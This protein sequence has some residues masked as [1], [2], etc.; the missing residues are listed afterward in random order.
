MPLMVWD[1]DDLIHNIEK[2]YSDLSDEIVKDIARR[3]MKGMWGVTE[4]AA[5][6]AQ[7]LNDSG[8]VY[9][10]ILG[11]VNARI[12]W[13]KTELDKAFKAAGVKAVKYDDMIYKAAGLEPLV[14]N[15]SHAAQTV[16]VAGLEKTGGVMENLAMSMP[17]AG[18]KLYLDTVDK[19]YMKVSSGAFS[20]TE[21][22]RSAIKEM[23]AKGITVVKYT[24]KVDQIDVAMRRAMLTGIS[25][26]ANR[27]QI[28]RA[29]EIGADYV[30]VSAHIGARPTHQV[31]QGKIYS[32]RGSETKYGNFVIETHYGEG[33]GLGGWNCRHS[34]F[35][36]F[37]GISADYY[38]PEEL[39]KYEG[40]DV[41]YNG[42][43]MD[44]YSAT[45]QQRAIE[46]EIR[47]WKRQADALGAA[48]LDNQFELGKKAEWQTTM[49]D[50][51]KQ[52]GLVRQPT[53]EG[54]KILRVIKPGFVP[55][56]W[57]PGM[58]PPSPNL[59]NDALWKKVIAK[60]NKG[61]AIP[62]LGPEQALLIKL[63]ALAAP[64]G[65][66]RRMIAALKAHLAD[67]LKYKVLIELD[68]TGKIGAVLGYSETFD[69]YT[70]YSFGEI[71][72]GMGLDNEV[73]HKLFQE[74]LQ[75]N[76]GIFMVLGTAG[77]PP[78][79]EYFAMKSY[80]ESL[81]I[82]VQNMKINIPKQDVAAQWITTF[83]QD[84]LVQYLAANP[85][86]PIPA[87]VV[88][89]SVV[90]LPQ[91]IIG[92][93]L[94]LPGFSK[95]AV[96][97]KPGDQLL[98]DVAEAA[99]MQLKKNDY[100]LYL[101]GLEKAGNLT[102]KVDRKM[103]EMLKNERAGG[104]KTFV[105]LDAQGNINSM[106]VYSLPT[107]DLLHIDGI[108]GNST[109]SMREVMKP[110]F[111]EAMLE[112]RMIQVR[113]ITS[114]ERDFYN[115]IGF[116]PIAGNL[117]GLDASELKPL[118]ISIWG[119]NSYAAFATKY[120]AILPVTPLQAFS[121]LPQHLSSINTGQR[122]I[123]KDGKAIIIG[124]PPKYIRGAYEKAIV[125][126][127]GDGDA[128]IKANYDP[129]GHLGWGDYNYSITEGLAYRENGAYEV[130][131]LLHLGI[132]PKSQ[133]F[134]STDG[135]TYVLIELKQ[136]TAKAWTE[137]E[138]L[139]GQNK[140]TYKDFLAAN[141]RNKEEGAKLT[142][143][144]LITGQRDRNGG[145]WMVDVMSNKTYA[146]DNG[147]SFIDVKNAATT[148]AEP[149]NGFQNYRAMLMKNGRVP[150]DPIYR[151]YLQDAIDNGKLYK[152]F[153]KAIKSD[154]PTDDIRVLNAVMNRAREVVANWDVYF[155]AP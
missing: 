136:N 124:T 40:P 127:D 123:S 130:D 117:L 93:Q 79:A 142:L 42:V 106:V 49:R 48:G 100:L 11:K 85:V 120:A 24:G 121:I 27:I 76:K 126:I 89:P 31:W 116:N 95:V 128:L 114:A 99:E 13:T 63:E 87:G 70:I 82:D 45:Q 64:K 68:A 105:S 52:T 77:Q 21:V 83:G 3:I 92:K 146:I 110:L 102:D 144:N 71:K 150:L 88:V 118:F 20:Y 145:N 26:T 132:T 140:F 51:I 109:L 54:F 6:Q 112:N 97:A 134:I 37:P 8:E 57:V 58:G 119:Q 35:P 90:P 138:T 131:E 155:V 44:F 46:R 149:N 154:L 19:M 23:A 41:T 107:S 22:M 65:N 147:L 69:Y 12:G 53:R 137:I 4:T 33:D 75:N 34:F 84:D 139:G 17:N 86:L 111:Q 39:K 1:M 14:L 30:Q 15:L 73:L 108:V 59:K 148:W 36:Y 50:F 103:Y 133:M 113:A 43:D 94:P 101:Q 143:L 29:Y 5:I 122:F 32:L 125:H 81:S 135:R 2:T 60:V 115:S 10:D 74:A 67:P 16:L 38:T 151:K 91:P 9:E 153:K 141:P 7:L 62:A 152:A 56:H 61:V 72:Q 18:Q 25:Q 80:F 129:Q 28:D 55:P 96:I 98:Y 66:E 104:F 78:T 47:R